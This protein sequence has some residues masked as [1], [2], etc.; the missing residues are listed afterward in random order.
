VR[1]DTDCRVTSLWKA[2]LARQ[3]WAVFPHD[4][5]GGQPMTRRCR[6]PR[7][8]SIARGKTR[9]GARKWR[10]N[11]LHATHDGEIEPMRPAR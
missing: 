4:D 10:S 2:T 5:D 1:R 7:V 3:E 6:A 8:D 11:E 9:A